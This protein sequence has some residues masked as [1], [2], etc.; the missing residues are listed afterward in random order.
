MTAKAFMSI[1]LD[2]SLIVVSIAR[3]AEMLDYINKSAGYAV[4]ILAGGTEA[5]VSKRGAVSPYTVAGIG[6]GPGGS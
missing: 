5:T 4:P 2:P 6:G 1:S 3:A